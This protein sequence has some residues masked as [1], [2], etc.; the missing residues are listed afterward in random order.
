MIIILEDER[1]TE[2]CEMAL[3]EMAEKED[4]SAIYTPLPLS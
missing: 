2:I 1:V 3:Q 4:K